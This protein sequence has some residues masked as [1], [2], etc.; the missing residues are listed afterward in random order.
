MEKKKTTKMLHI[1]IS[2]VIYHY[3][4][5]TNHNVPHTKIIPMK[6]IMMNLSQPGFFFWF[7]ILSS[8][9][10]AIIHKRNEPNLPRSQ[11]S[12]QKYFSILPSFRWPTRTHYRNRATFNSFFSSKYGDF[13]VIFSKKK[14]TLRAIHIGF[15]FL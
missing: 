5:P 13:C 15:P 14:K 4:S 8:T 9:W 6:M 3:M 11:R 1:E 12:Q 10:T 7:S 2:Y